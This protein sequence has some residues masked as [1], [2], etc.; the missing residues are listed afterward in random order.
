MPVSEEPSESA[1][2]EPP[3]EGEPPA[4]APTPA[5]EEAAAPSSPRKLSN[6]LRWSTASELENFGFDVYRSTSEE[7]PF[8]RITESP[9]PGAGT[10]DEPSR[11]VFEDE[12]IEPGVVYYYY[13]ESISMAGVRENFTPVIKAKAKTLEAGSGG[14]PAGDPEP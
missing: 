9:I 13:V 3:T 8:E 1:E 14:E 6:T 10:V 12:S 2:D 11:Y 4:D 7:G 5:A